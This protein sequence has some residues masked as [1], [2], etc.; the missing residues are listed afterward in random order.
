MIEVLDY[1]L[2]GGGFWQPHVGDLAALVLQLMNLAW[3][4][5]HFKA[6]AYR[7]EPLSENSCLAVDGE[8]FPF[9]PFYI[10]VHPGLARVLSPYGY[11][12][13]TFSEPTHNAA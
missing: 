7:L 4:Q 1:G 2:N 5:H 6:E 12:N 3:Q 8:P 13:A 11:F 10:E 9:E